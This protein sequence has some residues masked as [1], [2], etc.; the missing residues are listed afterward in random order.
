MTELSVE[1]VKKVNEIVDRITELTQHYESV[2][3]GAALSESVA[4]FIAAHPPELRNPMLDLFVST[5]TRIWP[6][7]AETMEDESQ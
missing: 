7:I 6:A 5:V 3:I 4:C 2:V 1:R